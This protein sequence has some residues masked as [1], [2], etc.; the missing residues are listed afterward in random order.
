MA[1]RK[2]SIR[3]T[4]GAAIYIDSRPEGAS[5][6]VATNWDYGLQIRHGLH[7]QLVQRTSDAAL[8]IYRYGLHD[9]PIVLMNTAA[10]LKIAG[11]ESRQATIVTPSGNV[12]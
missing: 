10:G 9:N 7:N 2:P 12:I 4:G 1:G 8:E 3:V 11:A 6:H 5:N